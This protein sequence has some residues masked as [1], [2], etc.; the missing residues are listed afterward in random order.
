MR[1]VAFLIFL[2]S[3]LLSHG[4]E[5][6][7]HVVVL[8]D[9]GC[10]IARHH[11]GTLRQCHEQFATQGV[12]FQGFVPNALATDTSMHAY[13]KKFQIPFTVHPDPQQQK[14]TELKATIVPE[15]FVFDAAQKLV[16]RGRIDDTYAAIG[17]RRPQ[18]QTHDLIRTLNAIL[19]GSPIPSAQTTPIGCAITFT[20]HASNS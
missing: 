1:L 8:L 2:T 17:K 12:D 5:I 11:L 15:V 20:K 14:A 7:A 13:M 3:S 18:A 4:A 10:P 16:Y 9:P 19:S 6:K